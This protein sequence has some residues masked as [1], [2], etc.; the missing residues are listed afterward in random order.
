MNREQRRKQAKA[1]RRNPNSKKNFRIVGYEEVS[2]D[3][4]QHDPNLKECDKELLDLMTKA[5][6][7][8][9]KNDASMRIIREGLS[10][11]DSLCSLRFDI[12]PLDDKKLVRDTM[13]FM[14]DT[15]NLFIGLYYELNKQQTLRELMDK[16]L[17]KGLTTVPLHIP[18][19]EDIAPM[20]GDVLVL[21]SNNRVDDMYADFVVEHA[22]DLAN[23]LY[24]TKYSDVSGDE[25]EIFEVLL[26]ISKK[27][28]LLLP[29]ADA[30]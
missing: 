4:I 28:M 5:Y 6:D 23:A 19:H 30:A 29:E 26:F 9:I 17:A 13:H 1:E 20:Y 11:L 16:S 2:I 10:Y 8:N 14:S 24:D 18:K 12:T 22:N 3:Q 15:V 27:T 25:V 7:W 21:P